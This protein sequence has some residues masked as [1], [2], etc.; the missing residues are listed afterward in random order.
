VLIGKD[1]LQDTELLVNNEEGELYIHS[2]PV[3]Y[4]YGKLYN[5]F[6]P[7]TGF[8]K[9]TGHSKAI[10]MIISIFVFD[11]VICVCYFIYKRKIVRGSK[12][13]KVN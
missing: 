5:K 3:N 11:V 7:E 2:D 4:Y 6:Q 10:I 12:Y 8:A 1:L 9:L 13:V